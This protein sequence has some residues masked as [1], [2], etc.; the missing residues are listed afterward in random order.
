MQAHYPA[1]HAEYWVYMLAAFVIVVLGTLRT[2]WMG[3]SNFPAGFVDHLHSYQCLMMKELA[4][5]RRLDPPRQRGPT[6]KQI[7]SGF[8]TLGLA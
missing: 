2:R 8:S 3:R 6:L 1:F 4:S 5:V 7:G